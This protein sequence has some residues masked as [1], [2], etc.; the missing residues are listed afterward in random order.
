[1][2]GPVYLTYIEVFWNLYQ[3][4]PTAN[5]GETHL[6]VR[7]GKPSELVSEMFFVTQTKTGTMVKQVLQEQMVGVRSYPSRELFSSL[8]RVCHVS[9]I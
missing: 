1:M 2:R 8:F 7:H 4:D 9:V 6:Y 5:A 3:L